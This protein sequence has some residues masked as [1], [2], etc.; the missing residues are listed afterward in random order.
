MRGGRIGA[1]IRTMLREHDVH[2]FALRRVRE[3]TGDLIAPAHACATWRALYDGLAELER[4]LME[5]IHLENHVLFPRA[6]A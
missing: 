2:A 3:L 1:P 4:E 5:H 6:D